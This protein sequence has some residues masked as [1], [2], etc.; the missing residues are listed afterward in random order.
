MDSTLSKI[1]NELT[2]NTLAIESLPNHLVHCDE[3][4]L[5]M[6]GEALTSTSTL[7][8][9]AS[10]DVLANNLGF[11]NREDL[12]V[13]ETLSGEGILSTVKDVAVKIYEGIAAAI[14][15]TVSLIGRFIAW[16]MSLFGKNSSSVSA[17]KVAVEEAA[18]T[19]EKAIKEAKVKPGD[20]V[21]PDEQKTMGL[22]VDDNSKVVDPRILERNITKT[23]A[24]RRLNLTGKK[25][26][27]REA[28]LKSAFEKTATMTNSIDIVKNIQEGS[29]FV[30]NFVNANPWKEI[31]GAGDIYTAF[32]GGDVAQGIQKAKS[33]LTSLETAF[34]S[35]EFFTRKGR[36]LEGRPLPGLIT[37]DLLRINVVNDIP[38]KDNAFFLKVKKE[39]SEKYTD[40]QFPK[41]YGDLDLG[42]DVMEEMGKQ[43]ALSESAVKAAENHL[44]IMVDFTGKFGA[45]GQMAIDATMGLENKDLDVT[46]EDKTM[47]LALVRKIPSA[48]DNAIRLLQYA[49]ARLNDYGIASKIIAEECRNIAYDLKKPPVSK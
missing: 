2:L 35:S 4:A 48:V 22:M 41:T 20:K 16:V 46:P 45:K 11:S 17:A 32:S 33:L 28:L 21:T 43:M 49:V 23:I 8:V 14:A 31:S 37:I 27:N 18:T 47:A 13:Y 38:E 44:A 3:I 10:L 12:G 6:S 26:T 1:E 7:V 24:K 15:K 42:I 25:L 30:A 19:Q 5:T 40:S 36:I 39:K 34:L 29:E 9:N